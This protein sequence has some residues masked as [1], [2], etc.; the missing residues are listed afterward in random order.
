QGNHTEFNARM[1]RLMEP[2]WTPLVVVRGSDEGQ[3]YTYTREDGDKFKVII[4]A[5]GDRD[6]TVLEV[7]LNE[8]EFF[9][10]LLNPEQETKNISDAATNQSTDKDN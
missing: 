2:R 9:K 5:L 6:G 1:R 8:E 10:L 4:I 3:T 7:G